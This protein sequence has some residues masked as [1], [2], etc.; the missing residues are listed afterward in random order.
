LHWLESL[1]Q[2]RYQLIAYDCIGHL[3]LDLGLNE[4]VIEHMERGLA[5]GDDTGIQFWR[6]AIDAHLAVARSRLGQK[7]VAHALQATL[8][9]TRHTS[10]RYMMIRCID[11]LAEIALAAGDAR[12]CRAYG[13]ELL[14]IAES[15][16]L[17]EL[18]AVARR[19]RG[20]ALLAEKDYVEAQAELSSAA[21]LAQDIGRVRL[22]MDAEAALA[23][24][25]GAQ[26]QN[27][28]SQR[29][30]ANA[31]AIAGAIEKSLESSGL[32]ARLRMPGDSR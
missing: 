5:L 18:E 16:G 26:G 8:E 21:T 17:R 31:R 27:D 14:A 4:Q 19:W 29:H 1:R 10:E 20:E 9:Q 3:L 15:N 12:R 23:R 6:A 22:Q 11:G 24:L 30:D 25:F 7:N 28:A 13:D 32:K 2:V